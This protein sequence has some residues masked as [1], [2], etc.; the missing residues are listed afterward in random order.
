MAESSQVGSVAGGD[1]GSGG[2][3]GW[4]EIKDLIR[5]KQCD[6]RLR[7]RTLIGAGKWPKNVVAA[8]KINC[9][10]TVTSGNSG[11]A[12]GDGR[13]RLI[14]GRMVV[15]TI[16]LRWPKEGRVSPV[17]SQ[18]GR[19]AKVKTNQDGG[20]VTQNQTENASADVDGSH[21]AMWYNLNA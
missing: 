11:G 16:L 7:R 3:R 6:Y 4:S 21:F 15:T 14:A 17:A 13:Y 18:S 5:M 9:K 1:H 2:S 20:K 12:D 10:I 8:A 19:S